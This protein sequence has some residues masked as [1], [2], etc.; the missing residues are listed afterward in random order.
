[1]IEAQCGYDHAPAGRGRALLAHYGPSLI[2]NIGFD[3]D[4]V[5]GFGDVPKPD[6][7]GLDALIDTGASDNY[8]DRALTDAMALPLIDQDEI[9]SPL[10]KQ[11]VNL[12][13]AQFHI[14]ALKKV[15]STKV[16]SVNLR[17]NGIE[18]DVLLGRT[19]LQDY[20]FTYDGT[21]GR[22]AIKRPCVAPLP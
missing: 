14:I 7:K 10:G 8:L 17:A 11:V 21:T 3:P 22:A 19:F 5:S 6:E 9:S 13:L 18:F 2:V 4:F 15:I 1:M 20:V 16:A 12:H